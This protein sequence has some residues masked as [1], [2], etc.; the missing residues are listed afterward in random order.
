MVAPGRGQGKRI[1]PLE[2][3][4]RRVGVGVTGEGEEDRE[5]EGDVAEG[6]GEERLE[7]LARRHVD[8][9]VER[10]GVL[11]AGLGAQR[12]RDAAQEHALQQPDTERGRDDLL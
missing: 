9:H 3:W 4:Y 6:H 11:V 10:D 8:G 2:L 12:A 1:D 7:G 5:R